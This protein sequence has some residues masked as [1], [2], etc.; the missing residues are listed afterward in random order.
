[1]NNLEVQAAD[2]LRFQK[3]CQFVLFERNPRYQIGSP[4]VLGITRN[5]YLFEIEIKRSLSDFKANA[6]KRHVVNRENILHLWPKMFWYC[7]PENLV[8]K[9]KPFLPPYAGL[10]APAGYSL[11]AI[12]QSKTNSASHRL[13]LSECARLT[14]CMSNQLWAQQEHIRVLRDRFYYGNDLNQDYCI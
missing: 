7:V 10:L 14:H 6:G 2:W 4:D 8:E 3:R 5:R 13:S 12:S 11:C 9:V 1:M